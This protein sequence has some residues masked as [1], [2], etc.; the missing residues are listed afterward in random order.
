ME[1]GVIV[2][3]TPVSLLVP[4]EVCSVRAIVAGFVLVVK[5]GVIPLSL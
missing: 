2:G 1:R 3:F 5:A 4:I